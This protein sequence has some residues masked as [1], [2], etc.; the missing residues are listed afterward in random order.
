MNRC[1]CSDK[2]KLPFSKVMG[3]HIPLHP[4]D[5]T[6]TPTRSDYYIMIGINP[7]HGQATGTQYLCQKTLTASHVE[8]AI[9][10]RLTVL[11]NQI[12]IV[13]IMVPTVLNEFLHS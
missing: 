6:L 3:Q 11:K 7:C 8:C 5:S 4:S 1:Y 12:M 13:P 9:H 10:C 2:I